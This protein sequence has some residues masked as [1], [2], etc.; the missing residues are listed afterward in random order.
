M[1]KNA[2]QLDTSLMSDIPFNF[3]V[4]EMDSPSPEIVI[5]LTLRG[6]RNSPMITTL[7]IGGPCRS[8]PIQSPL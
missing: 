4:L 3:S 5:N 8:L 7:M 1:T 6:S 2:L